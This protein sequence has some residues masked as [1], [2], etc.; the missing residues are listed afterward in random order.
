MLYFKNGVDDYVIQLAD[1]VKGSRDKYKALAK[2]AGYFS[3]EYYDEVKEH[4]DFVYH[5]L[6]RINAKFFT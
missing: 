5:F 6:K 3:R 2:Q 1:E 4:V